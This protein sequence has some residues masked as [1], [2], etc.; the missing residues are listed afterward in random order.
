MACLLL[1]GCAGSN[2]GDVLDPAKS[3]L[4]G[5]WEYLVTN[6]Y[7]ATFTGC[8]GDAEV[9][10]GRTLHEGKS[11]APICL[12]AVSFE[13]SQ[14]GEQFEVPPHP[15]TCSDGVGAAVSGSG[16]IVDPDLG[17]QWESMSDQGVGAVQLFTG[18]IV[19]NTIQL[20]ETRRTFSGGFEG[21]CDLSPPVT[22]LV[23]VR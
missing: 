15:V 19:G 5:T 13:V 20:T 18:V 10:E 2:D 6:A 4:D 11:V 16:S 21:E 23:T 14:T 22:A 12:A 3:E 17:G 9:L 8:S 1:A 7:D